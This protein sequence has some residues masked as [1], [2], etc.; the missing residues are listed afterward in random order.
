MGKGHIAVNKYISDR[1]RFADLINGKLFNG[2]QIVLPEEL[3]KI[4]GE[5]EI[6]LEDKNGKTSAKTRYRDIVMRW[7]KGVDFCFLA[8]E[9]QEEVHYAMPVRNMLYDSLSYTNQIAEIWKLH[10]KG[11]SQGLEPAEYLS[12]FRKD[13]RIFPIITI[14]FYYGGEPWTGNR[15]LYSMFRM[16]QMEKEMFEKYIPNYWINLVDA[17]DI[18]D[19]TCF[20][21]D[22]QKIMGMLKCKSNKEKLLK[23]AYENEDFF[24]H[25]D[26]NTW[27][28][29]GEFL[30]SKKLLK[31]VVKR[32]DVKGE[33]NM[34]KALEDLYQSGEHKGLVEVYQEDGRSKEDTIIRFMSKFQV[35]R[36][37]AEERVAE[38][39]KE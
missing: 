37:E 18:E 32:E 33:A 17:D 31:K 20:K 19:I 26:Y 13:D 8:C 14:V 28:A 15:D 22:L 34:C 4:E 36:E 3:E 30:Q 27:L 21:T 9:N 29:I 12:R 38:Y 25:V 24:G 1:A 23:Y 35:R 16:S 39:W 5:S 2:Q 11:K 6:L 7:S 10:N